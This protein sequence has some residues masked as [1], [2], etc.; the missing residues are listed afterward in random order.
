MQDIA[1]EATEKVNPGI[2]AMTKMLMDSAGKIL[3]NSVHDVRE[4]IAAPNPMPYYVYHSP[5]PPGAMRPV[6]TQPPPNPLPTLPP[7][8][9][10]M[11]DPRLMKEVIGEW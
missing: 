4:D 1:N 11:P 2:I 7:N 9:G 8:F 3:G 5:P 10:K 6:F